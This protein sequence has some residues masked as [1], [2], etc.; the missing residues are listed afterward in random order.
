MVSD[1]T[2]VLEELKARALVCTDC[3]LSESRTK[4]VFGVG[5]P[6]ARLMLLG[7]APGKNEDLKGEP[8]VASAIKPSTNRMLFAG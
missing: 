3:E 7:E 8:F 6:D 4:V 2:S 1:R 5:D